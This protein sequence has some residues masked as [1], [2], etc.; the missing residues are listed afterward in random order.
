MKTFI[1]KH[2][3]VEGLKQ[4]RKTSAHT[5]DE[6]WTKI[7]KDF[8][9]NETFIWDQ[10][11]LMMVYIKKQEAETDNDK[12]NT[13]KIVARTIKNGSTFKSDYLPGWGQ[14]N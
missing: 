13:Y 8:K 5:N 14:R 4:A 3:I 7:I 10:A 6:L 1:T 12:K 2:E 9:D 11:E